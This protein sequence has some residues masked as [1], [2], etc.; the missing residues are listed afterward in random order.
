MVDRLGEEFAGHEAFL[1]TG[2][3]QAGEQV[4]IVEVGDLADEGVQVAC[5]GHPAGPGTGDGVVLEER[6]EFKR[7]GAVGVDAVRV[8][9]F[10]RVELP[11]AADD[12]FAVAGL[13]PVEVAGEPLVL[14]MGEFERRLLVAVGVGVP[15]E[16]RFE[17]ADAVKDAGWYGSGGPHLAAH[18]VE[19][20][21]VQVICRVWEM[22]RS[23]YYCRSQAS[24][25]HELR[26][27]LQR[28]AGQ[29]PRYGSR[30][31][32]AQLQRE[33]FQ[34]K[35]NIKSQRLLG[36][37]ARPWHSYQMR[38]SYSITSK[39]STSSGGVR[40]RRRIIIPF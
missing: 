33:G 12:D 5:K 1:E 32:A 37:I 8:G 13:P 29:W 16:V 2:G 36:A 30:R 22:P 38:P 21:P 39:L 20:Y 15:V 23:T 27:A 25:E 6:E 35:G 31:L 40:A 9:C 11:V 26:A 28:L 14:A 17:G 3:T 24:D 7:V 4:E 10:G 18:G 19:S 34:V